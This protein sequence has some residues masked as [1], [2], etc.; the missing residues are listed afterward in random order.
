MLISRRKAITIFQQ[1]TGRSVDYSRK[2]IAGLPNEKDGKREKVNTWHLE[3]AITKANEVVPV[4]TSRSI[5]PI[6]DRR[7]QEIRERCI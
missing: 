1:E 7:A 3:R 2:A 4:P 5:R 6:S